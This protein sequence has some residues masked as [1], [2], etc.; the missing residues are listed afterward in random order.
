MSSRCPNCGG[1]ATT[2]GFQ[3]APNCP[4]NP[5]RPQPDVW[6]RIEECM[7]AEIM[8]GVPTSCLERIAVEVVPG[9]QSACFASERREKRGLK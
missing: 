4:H 7:K 5:W 2:A 1:L 6:D 3:H 8:S 9:H